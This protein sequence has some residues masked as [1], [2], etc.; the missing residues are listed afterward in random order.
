M[1]ILLD[2]D[3]ADIPTAQ[4][5]GVRVVKGIPMF[6]KKAPLQ[7]FEKLLDRLLAPHIA[8]P[9]A[10]I[11][12]KTPIFLHISYLFGYPK[13]APKSSRVDLAPMTERP[14]GDNMSK[15]IIDALGDKMA[16]DRKTNRWVCV[17]RGFFQD[18]AAISTLV[19]SKYR[20]TGKPRVN[21]CISPKSEW[22]G[23]QG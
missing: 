9:G 3:P 2:I 11:P 22:A 18:D 4:E 21:I 7:R 8:K 19:I 5:K 6:Y 1:N 15:A 12:A 13:S 20:T 10:R 17:R 23:A 16:K 14:D